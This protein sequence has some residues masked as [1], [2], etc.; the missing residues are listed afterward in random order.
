MAGVAALRVREP[1]VTPAS[2]P[3]CRRVRAV[4]ADAAKRDP[5]A[6]STWDGE[7]RGRWRANERARGLVIVNTGNGKGKTTAALGLAMRAAGNA[8]ACG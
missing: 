2:R 8:C 5:T 3:A 6:L 1:P 4:P 7:A